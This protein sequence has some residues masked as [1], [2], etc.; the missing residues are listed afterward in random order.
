MKSIVFAML[1]LLSTIAYSAEYNA[2]E[3]YQEGEI[4][5]LDFGSSTLILQGQTYDVSGSAQV[6]IN[7]TYGAFTMLEVGMRVAAVYRRY[8]DGSREIVQLTE[9]PD[10]HELLVR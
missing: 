5:S 9:L 7:G 8:E 4:H 2:P 6:E 10:S 1:M 3:A